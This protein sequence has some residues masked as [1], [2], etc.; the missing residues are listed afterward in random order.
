MVAKRKKLRANGS[1]HLLLCRSAKAP[2]VV[3]LSLTFIFLIY[4]NYVSRLIVD[5][6]HG[7]S[8][9][10]PW[11]DAVAPARK[12]E[13]AMSYK[14]TIKEYIP[15]SCEKYIVE[16]AE[17]LGY[18]STK[19][20]TT[21]EHGLD[22]ARGCAIWS[23]PKISNEDVYNSLHS[24]LS[25]LDKYNEAMKNFEPIPDLFDEIREGNYDACLSA[26]VHPDGLSA[27]FPSKQLSLSKS[28]Y[29]EPITP[30]MRS[31]KGMCISGGVMNLDYLIHDFEAMCRNLKPTSRRVFI[32]LGASL[33]H[34]TGNPVGWLLG[35]YEKFGFRFDHIYGFEIEFAKPEDVYGHLL[36]EKYFAAYHWI[37]VGE[38]FITSLDISK[39]HFFD[40]ILYV[41]YLY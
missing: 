31:Y 33:D 40:V 3:L 17:K 26:R 38:I 39:F 11:Q 7:A 13:K 1:I 29:V 5:L 2:Y 19:V 20:W 10:L 15:A 16:H 14:D 25:D 34:G 22:L 4:M 9:S 24:Y 30:P 8:T 35:E 18:G 21:D 28:G 41:I 36:D 12:S 23:D 32:D 27:L 6:A 37:N